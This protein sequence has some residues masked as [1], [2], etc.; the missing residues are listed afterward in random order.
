MKLFK[1]YYWR[2]IVCNACLYLNDFLAVE[3]YTLLCKMQVLGSEDWEMKRIGS[4]LD[5]QQL[6]RIKEWSKEKKD[7]E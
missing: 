1:D 4:N 6:E 7:A 5:I 2:S 3:S